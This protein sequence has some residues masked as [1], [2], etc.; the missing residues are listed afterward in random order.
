MRAQR[1]PVVRARDGLL[2]RVWRLERLPLRAVTARAVLSLL[3][4][5]LDDE[6]QDIPGRRSWPSGGCR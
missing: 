6:W 1:H 2:E 4:E 3:P 5:E